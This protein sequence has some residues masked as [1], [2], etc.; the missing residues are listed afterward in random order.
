MKFIKRKTPPELR[1]GDLE[2]GEMFRA[3]ECET[4]YYKLST[5]VCLV[6]RGNV[7]SYNALALADGRFFCFHESDTV[8]RISG[9]FVEGAE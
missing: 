6:P 5:R 9:A 1:F 4:P 3:W 7:P 8:T 2:A